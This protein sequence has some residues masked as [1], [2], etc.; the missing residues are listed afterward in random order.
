MV[1]FM[2]HS[3]RSASTPRLRS[4]GTSIQEILGETRWFSESTW[5]KLYNKPLVSSKKNEFQR[6]NTL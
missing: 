3:T 1:F 5:Q 6:Q 2:G 4:S